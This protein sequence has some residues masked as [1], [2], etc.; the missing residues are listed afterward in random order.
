MNKVKAATCGVYDGHDLIV[1]AMTKKEA[2]EAEIKINQLIQTAYLEGLRNGWR[3]H[4]G[5]TA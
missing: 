2:Q 3:N 4:R 1:M 5:V